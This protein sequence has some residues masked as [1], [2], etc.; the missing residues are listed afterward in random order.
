MAVRSGDEV[1]TVDKI[2]SEKF[3][4]KENPYTFTMFLIESSLDSEVE[5]KE[6]KKIDRGYEMVL[7]GL[8][9]N[10]EKQI[11]IK[12]LIELDNGDQGSVKVVISSDED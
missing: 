7:S 11:Y 2:T 6:L 9:N 1:N 10:S 3:I 12:S 8:K 5:V 4:S